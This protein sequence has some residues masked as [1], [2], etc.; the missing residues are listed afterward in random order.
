LIPSIFNDPALQLSFATKHF[1]LCSFLPRHHAASLPNIDLHCHL[2]LLL[3]ANRDP[4]SL[5]EK[6]RLDHIQRTFDHSIAFFEEVNAKAAPIPPHHCHLWLLIFFELGK[7]LST[8][9]EQQKREFIK[10][11]EVCMK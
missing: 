8:V 5:R 4:L 7:Y 1:L 2:F 9:K 6:F 11:F 3:E 10:H